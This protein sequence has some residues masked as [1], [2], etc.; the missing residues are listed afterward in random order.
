MYRENAES[1]GGWEAC[2]ADWEEGRAQSVDDYR[3]Y[4]PWNEGRLQ[5]IREL[6]CCEARCGPKTG[7]LINFSR[8]A[9]L[10]EVHLED[11]GD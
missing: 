7:E 11:R 8:L 4:C 1:V 6:L 3:W 9:G 10:V 5:K 2:R